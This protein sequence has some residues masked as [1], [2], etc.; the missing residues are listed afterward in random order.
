[1]KIKVSNTNGNSYQKDVVRVYIDGELVAEV[2]PPKRNPLGYIRE[3]NGKY[4]KD[5]IS[6][7]RDAGISDIDIVSHLGL[8]GDL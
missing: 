5:L 3:H 4:R 8:K 1:M 7:C 2:F 6:Q